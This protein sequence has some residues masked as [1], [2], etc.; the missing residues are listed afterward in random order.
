[1]KDRTEKPISIRLDAD[2][3]AR[4]KAMQT[5]LSPPLELTVSQVMRSLLLR[6]LDA[7]EATPEQSEFERGAEAMRE[8]MATYMWDTYEH[9]KRDPGLYGECP[10]RYREIAEG[11]DLG[12]IPR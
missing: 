8:R 12:A 9:A 3:Y 5:K 6:A 2:L 11:L 10:V 1:M 7:V 4:L